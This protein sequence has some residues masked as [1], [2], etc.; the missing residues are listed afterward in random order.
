MANCRLTWTGIG[1]TIFVA[2]L[3]PP[4][5]P[6]PAAGPPGPAPD[7]PGIRPL[8]EMP[9]FTRFHLARRFW[10]QILTW[11]SLNLKLCAICDRSDRLRYFFEWNS[12]SSSKSCSLVNAVLRRRAFE[13]ELAV[14]FPPPPGPSNFE[15]T[16]SPMLWPSVSLLLSKSLKSS[17]SLDSEVSPSSME[18][19]KYLKGF[20]VD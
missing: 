5:G 13:A 2:E 9:A 20:H 15:L 14:E 11:T 10:N 3:P 18:E 4:D 1:T 12:F 6:R 8:L 17:S 19:I 16:S 7:A